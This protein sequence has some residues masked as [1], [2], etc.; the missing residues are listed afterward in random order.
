[1]AKQVWE[2]RQLTAFAE[3]PKEWAVKA[4]VAHYRSGKDT[5]FTLKWKS[6]DETWCDLHTARKLKALKN[7]CDLMRVMGVNKLPLG[8]THKPNDN[9]IFMAV[10]TYPV[11]ERELKRADLEV[12]KE[13]RPP[14]EGLTHI[15]C[16]ASQFDPL[17][18]SLALN[19]ISI[20]T[21]IAIS[22]LM[23][24]NKGEGQPDTGS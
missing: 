14:F 3:E 20:R 8:T 12:M 15:S 13:A 24:K 6:G 21:P 2:I 1:M 17:A 19:S 22:L 10:M 23:A 4:I 18:T 7:F 11:W 9:K 16:N 5:L